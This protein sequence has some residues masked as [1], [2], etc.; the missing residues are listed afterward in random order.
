MKIYIDIYI[1]TTIL[2]RKCLYLCTAERKR[3]RE[4]ERKIIIIIF[5]PKT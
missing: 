3:E 4:K 5:A 2:A 1:F